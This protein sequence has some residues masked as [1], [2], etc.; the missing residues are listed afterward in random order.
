MF[1]AQMP[2]A[3][4]GHPFFH[5]EVSRATLNRIK[6]KKGTTGQQRKGPPPGKHGDAR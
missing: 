3:N 2:M 6:D 5:G 4:K 1:K